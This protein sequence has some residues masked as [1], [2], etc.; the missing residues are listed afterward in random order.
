MR[1]AVSFCKLLLRTQCRQAQTTVASKAVVAR[2]HV[3]VSRVFECR[4]LVS[5]CPPQR[6]CALVRP[7]ASLILLDLA[8]SLGL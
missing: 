7:A 2:L 4:F 3:G 5:C 8:A 1:R 6:T